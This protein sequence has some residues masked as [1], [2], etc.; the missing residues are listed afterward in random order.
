ME[1]IKSEENLKM[2]EDY[3]HKHHGT[4]PSVSLLNRC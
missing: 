3:E 2:E 4:F 1:S